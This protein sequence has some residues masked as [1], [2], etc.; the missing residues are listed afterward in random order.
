MKKL[1]P[2]M[3]R[4]VAQ[5]A[6]VLPPHVGEDVGREIYQRYRCGESPASLARRYSLNVT[7]VR[8]LLA[9][10]RHQRIEELPLEH[11]ANE[12][13]KRMTASREK[14]ILGPVPAPAKPPRQVRPAAGLPPYLASLYEVPLLTREQEIQLF[15]KMNYLKYKASHLAARLIRKHP[16][17]TLLDRIEELYEQS[18]DVKNEIIRA[19]LRLVV[20]FAK[21]CARS[22][23]SLFEMISDGNISL[24][25]AVEKFDYARGFKFSTYA[26][27]AIIRNFARTIPQENRYRT[28]FF[29]RGEEVIQT[30]W[31]E[32]T[33]QQAEEAAHA[34]R[35]D[36]IAR[37]MEHLDDR[38]KQIIR[39]RYG[40]G[41]GR[42]PM[43]L[44]E[45]GAQWA[46]RRS[47]SGSCKLG[48][49][50]SFARQLKWK[51]S[52]CPKTHSV[53]EVRELCHVE[54][55]LKELPVEHA[56]EL[57]RLIELHLFY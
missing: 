51:G 11:I 27:W 30:I 42:E 7:R 34:Q 57:K 47:G 25:R 15:R 33:N 41:P 20:A 28:R 52:T 24:I 26:T 56:V 35:Q 36:Q 31:D 55:L 50:P 12:E 4:Q 43:T 48:P 44:K 19:N 54:L 45:V 22:P 14:A 2:I 6:S 29:T 46:S 37:M 18:L 13:F 23:Q 38:E 8:R 5:V 17:N 53:C 16:D 9:R 32:R 49:S 21:R 10:I 40:L 39:Y 1:P 3:A